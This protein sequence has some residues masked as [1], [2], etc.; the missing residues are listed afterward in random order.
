MT[1][2]EI[3]IAAELV[4]KVERIAKTRKVSFS[5]IVNEAIN[6]FE[7]KYIPLAKIMLDADRAYEK[8]NI[9]LEEVLANALETYSKHIPPE[10]EIIL[11]EVLDFFTKEI[12]KTTKSI[13][14][15]LKKMDNFKLGDLSSK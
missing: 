13:D 8:G 5:R 4:S 2:I 6:D 15:T 14:E 11:G 9:S 12:K 1:K 3:D 10:E 7:E